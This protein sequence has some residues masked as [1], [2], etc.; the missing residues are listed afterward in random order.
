MVDADPYFSHTALPDRIEAAS[1]AC[2]KA[3]KV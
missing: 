2:A 3:N 1:W